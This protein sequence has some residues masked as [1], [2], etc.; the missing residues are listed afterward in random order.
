ML[1]QSNLFNTD[2]KGA[3]LSVCSREVRSRIIEEESI[4]ILVWFGLSELSGHNIEV[5]VLWR[6]PKGEVRLYDSESENA[7]LVSISPVGDSLVSLV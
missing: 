3:G 7:L 2:T 4:R 5:S 6:C 1:L